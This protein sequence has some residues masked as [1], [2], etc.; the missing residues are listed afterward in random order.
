MLSIALAT[1][2]GALVT[3]GFQYLR[4]KAKKTKTKVDDVLV[5]AGEAAAP[6]VIDGFT[7]RPV[8]PERPTRVD[9]RRK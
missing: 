3:A 9:H 6:V 5:D 1:A 8:P 4:G 2:L 7:K